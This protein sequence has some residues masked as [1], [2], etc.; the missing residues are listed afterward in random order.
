VGV[1]EVSCPGRFVVRYFGFAQIPCQEGKVLCFNDFEEWC[2]INRSQRLTI[3]VQF[4]VLRSDKCQTF[5]T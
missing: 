1:E 2:R 5:A 4:P 3:S